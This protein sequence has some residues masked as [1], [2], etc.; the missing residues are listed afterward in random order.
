MQCDLWL[1]KLSKAS[2][3]ILVDLAKAS[4]LDDYQKQLEERLSEGVIAQCIS[5][6]GE[7]AV[8]GIHMQGEKQQIF[9]F[10]AMLLKAS[11][12]F[13]TT[14]ISFLALQGV[15]VKEKEAMLIA[16]SDRCGRCQLAFVEYLAEQFP[17]EVASCKVLYDQFQESRDTLEA[18]NFGVL[19]DGPLDPFAKQFQ[20]LTDSM[21]HEVKVLHTFAIDVT[22]PDVSAMAWN[23]DVIADF[24]A[25]QQQKRE[26]GLLDSFLQKGRDYISQKSIASLASVVLPQMVVLVR[27]VW[28][29]F[30]TYFQFHVFE[31]ICIFKFSVCFILSSIS[32]II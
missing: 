24:R 2:A 8:I 29:M 1:Q 7:K 25:V 30:Q 20:N 18:T 15:V 19:L 10:A 4:G 27:E 31:F 16:M 11:E 12:R 28:L 13:R 23:P 9:T 22:R 3:T 32:C 26:N 21:R 17:A 14:D 6:A 5:H